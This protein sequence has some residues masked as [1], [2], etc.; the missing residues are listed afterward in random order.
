MQKVLLMAGVLLAVTANAA[1]YRNSSGRIAGTTTQS[2]NRTIY[3]D[4]SGRMTGSSECQSVL[5]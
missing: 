1:T 5:S 2:G 4:G 3:R